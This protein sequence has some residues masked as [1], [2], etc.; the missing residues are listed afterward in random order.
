[1]RLYLLARVID[2]LRPRR[3]LEVGSG[4]GIN[5]LVLAGM[6]PETEFVGLEL[7]DEGIRAG[8]GVQARGVLPDNLLSFAPAPIQDP[9]AFKRIRF[10]Q[11]SAADLPFGDGEFDLVYTSVA[12]EQM[13]SIRHRALGEIARTARDHV[14]LCEPFYDVNQSGIAR[15][16]VV[17]RDYFQG[18]IGDLPRYGLEPYWATNDLPH[19]INNCVCA[20]L[21][22]KSSKLSAAA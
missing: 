17:A 12:V 16:Y 13:E 20:V 11:G 8:T 2:T 1:M 9:A 3:V 22:R 21:C 14:F 15:R 19:K 10:E 18:P 7:T 6:F 4:N 5:L